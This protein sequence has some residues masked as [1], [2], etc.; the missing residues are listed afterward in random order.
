M[1]L[2]DATGR[3]GRASRGSGDHCFCRGVLI[4]MLLVDAKRDD[5]KMTSW[6]QAT[7]G[8]RQMGRA[9]DAANDDG[10]DRHTD[11]GC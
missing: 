2:D 3:T 11:V 7:G 9:S 4:R 1:L 5:G 10:D 6:M 8:G